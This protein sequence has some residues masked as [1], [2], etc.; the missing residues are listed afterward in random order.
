MTTTVIPGP[1]P[2]EVEQYLKDRRERGLDARDECWGG[3]YYV[4]PHATTG[5]AAVTAEVSAEIRARVRPQGLLVLAEFNL[6]TGP[7]DFTVPDGGV[8]TS[9]TGVYAATA[10][11]VV[12]VLSPEDATFD[13]FA[14]YAAHDVPELLLADPRARA[15]SCWQRQ[16]DSYVEVPGSEL[17]GV[18][19]AE[20]TAA[21]AWP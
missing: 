17:L 8:V 4:A 18:T 20:L 7:Q 14:H 11:L 15:V 5:H 2:A 10:L 12:E 9:E 3:R 21:I 6:G 16:G 1:V 19:A 13:K